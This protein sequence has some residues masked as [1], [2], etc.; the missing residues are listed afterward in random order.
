MIQRTA[1]EL[2]EL[3]E[4]VLEG[5]GTRVLVGPAALADARADQVSFVRS[6]RHAREFETTR[7]GAVI[8][9]FDLQ[10][11]RRDLALLRCHDPSRAFS[12]VVEAF[13]H[14]VPRP[15]AGIHPTAVVEP[16]ARVGLGASVGPLCFVGAGAELGERAVLHAGVKL[17]PRVRVGAESVLHPGVV[18]YDGVELGRRC[19]VH[20]GTVI[21]A[22]GFGFEP[23]QA[24]WEKVPQCG[25][26]VIGDDVEIGANCAIDRGR[27]DA[28]RIG[29]GVKLDN[30]VHVA[31]NV[32]IEDGALLVAQ[33]GVAGSARIG[34]RAVLAGQAGVVGHVHVGPGARIAAQSGIARD[35]PAGEDTF[36]SPA[37]EKGEAFRLLALY[38]KLPEL[39]RRLRALERKLGAGEEPD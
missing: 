26:V 14:P 36:G 10:A 37:R 23:T 8:V 16:S 32:I 31:H 7:A 19:L 34:A 12:R 5:D 27:F 39:F 6:A 18:L 20:A 21:G 3:C 9:P 28:T 1:S 13:R 2:A 24:G 25:T 4:A 15:P 17:G 22:D 29:N 11:G 30:L 33:V 35:V 38:G